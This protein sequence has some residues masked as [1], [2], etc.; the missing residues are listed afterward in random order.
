MNI[1]TIG[2]NSSVTIPLRFTILHDE[3]ESIHLYA[4]KEKNY[5]NW[6]K[7]TIINRLVLQAATFDP[8]YQ[9]LAGINQ[10]IFGDDKKKW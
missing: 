1:V 6:F 10:D 3:I 8:N 4:R 2:S 7:K 5:T 9:T